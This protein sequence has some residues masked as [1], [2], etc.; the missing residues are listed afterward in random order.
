MINRFINQL[1]YTFFSND[2]TFLSGII[3][4][5]ILTRALGPEGRGAYAVIIQFIAVL[6]VFALFDL[7]EKRMLVASGENVVIGNS[8][9]LPF[10]DNEFDYVISLDCEGLFD[11][12]SII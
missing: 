8:N 2:F 9:N 10:R 11:E 5:I 3:C 7:D 1:S 4:S 6:I 12:Q